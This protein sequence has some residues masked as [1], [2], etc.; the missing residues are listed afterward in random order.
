MKK[1]PTRLRARPYTY[2]RT[3]VGL[4]P[5]MQE[6]LNHCAGFYTRLIDRPI[7]RTLLLRRA[8]S[9]LREHV[10]RIHAAPDAL[11]EVG[12]LVAHQ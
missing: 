12:K 3:Q 4:T 8:V 6:D 2:H 11:L 1:K 5:E 10:D 7:S 9:A